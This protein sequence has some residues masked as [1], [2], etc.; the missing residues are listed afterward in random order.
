MAY[1]LL[2][3]GDFRMEQDS[4]AVLVVEV[5]KGSA[6]IVPGAEGL[7]RLVIFCQPPTRDQV[8]K[9]CS[10]KKNKECKTV[11]TICSP[12][13]ILVER[14][15]NCDPHEILVFGS[16]GQVP[17]DHRRGPVSISIKGF[18]EL[19]AWAER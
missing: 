4:N 16:R 13:I 18:E 12:S 10:E 9:A 17:V 7:L 2:L 6:Q 19:N 5:A 11:R 14:V 8:N 15:N 3:P 1:Q